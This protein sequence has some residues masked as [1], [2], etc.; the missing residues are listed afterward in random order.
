MT[1]GTFL[2]RGFLDPAVA[3]D[4]HPVAGQLRRQLVEEPKVVEER[5]H[6]VTSR[7]RSMPAEYVAV[8]VPEDTG[9]RGKSSRRFWR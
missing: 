2:Q 7:S 4:D 1:C 5:S 8:V 3:D 6:P 9:S